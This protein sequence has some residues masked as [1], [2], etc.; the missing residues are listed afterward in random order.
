[1][2]GR[3]TPRP[4]RGRP[5]RR[6][7]ATGSGIRSRPRRMAPGWWP[8]IWGGGGGQI[9]TSTD[10]GATWT[11]RDS[12]RDGCRSRPRRMA[13][14]WW[15]WLMAGRF[16]PRPIRGRPGPRATATGTGARSRPRR[17]A[18]G[19]SPWSGLA[20][21]QI[22]TSTDSGATWT[23]RDSNRNWFSVA[24]SADGTRL[25]AVVDGGQIYTS[26]PVLSGQAGTTQPCRYAGRWP[27]ATPG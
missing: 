9:Y 8:W 26:V 1:M 25:V 14:G 27:M 10:S 19:W 6:A 22:Y 12:N 2:V 5:G 16:T 4:I 7:T 15:L 13:P 3:F 21:R 17:M 18:P 23:P 20:W 24:S 11:P